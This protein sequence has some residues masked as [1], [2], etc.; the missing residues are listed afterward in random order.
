MNHPGEKNLN[1][2]RILFLIKGILDL[3]LVLV[4]VIYAS[5][6]TFMSEVMRQDALQYGRE[7]PMDPSVIFVTAGI[8]ITII[9]LLTGIPALMASARLNQKRGRTFIIVAAAINCLTG[10]LGIILCI[11]T[12]MELSK[13]QVKELF[14]QNDAV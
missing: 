6:G 9:A 8:I 7:M 2:Y 12:V 13:P 5:L 10:V 4:G 3:L 14:A 11:F 1:T